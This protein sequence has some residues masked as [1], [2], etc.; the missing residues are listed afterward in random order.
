[1]IRHLIYGRTIIASCLVTKIPN[2]FLAC[3]I[4]KWVVKDPSIDTT[5]HGIAKI[6]LNSSNT[7]TTD[8]EKCTPEPAWFE[9]IYANQQG[10]V[11]MSQHLDTRG[12]AQ[13]NWF[14]KTILKVTG[15][16]FFFRC[17]FKFGKMSNPPNKISLLHLA[18][19]W[20]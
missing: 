6:N 1:M 20:Q 11:P 2:Y 17:A 9:R 15:F 8:V 18:T 4:S 7:L 16:G 5:Y 19:T 14:P 10:V 12:Y 3:P 13:I